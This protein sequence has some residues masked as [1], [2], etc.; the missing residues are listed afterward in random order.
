MLRWSSISIIFIFVWLKLTRLLLIWISQLLKLLLQVFRLIILCRTW[1]S[2]WNWIL[3]TK[4]LVV[5]TYSNC[6]TTITRSSVLVLIKSYALLLYYLRL[7]LILNVQ[8]LILLRIFAFLAVADIFLKHVIYISHIIR[9]N[10]LVVICL[11]LVTQ[12]TKTS[13]W[14]RWM[15]SLVM[16][17]GVGNC[18]WSFCCRFYR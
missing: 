15:W 5:Y 14:S 6:R 7:F 9:V 3:S 10:L 13:E 12:T 2:R 11:N 8:I 16:N 1:I 18:V 17:T 4:A